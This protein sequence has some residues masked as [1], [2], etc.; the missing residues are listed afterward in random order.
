VLAANVFGVPEL[1][2]DGVNGWLFAPRDVGA[3]TQAIRTVVQLTREE[4]SAVG[5]AGRSTVLKRHSASAYGRS[6]F[7]LINETLAEREPRDQ[8]PAD[9]DAATRA[10]YRAVRTYTMTSAERIIALCDAVR[11]V[12]RYRIPGDIVE[13]GVWRGGSMLAAARTLVEC[14]DTERILWLY[15]TYSGMSEPEEV[16]RRVSDGV[17]ANDLLA[18]SERSADVWGISP[19]DEV[20]QTLAQCAYPAERM[21][22]VV[23]KVED[24]IPARAPETIALLRLDTDWYGSTRHELLHLLPRVSPGGVLI[25]DDYGDWQGARKAVDE[26][27]EATNLRVLLMRIDHTGRMALIEP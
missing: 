27:L 20:R 22:F 3:L 11:Y 16:D 5:R 26:Y 25:I 17:P 10:T 1:I 23:G 21:Q 15:D 8:L 7:E 19:L 2:S 6:F 12:S 9:V 4:R 18:A 24:T 13:C 14:N